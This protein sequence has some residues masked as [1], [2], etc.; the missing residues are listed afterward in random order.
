MRTLRYWEAIAEATVQAMDSDPSVF[1]LGIG[2]A[3][4]KGIFGTTL[5]ARK[6]FPARVIETP[7]CE[8][9]LTGIALG[10]ALRGLRPVLVHARCDFLVLSLNQLMNHAA[11]WE[12][13]CGRQAPV[14]VRAIVGRGW[15]QGPQHS[16]SLQAMLAHVPGLNVAMPATPYD[17]KG[18]LLAALAA[19]GPTVVLEHRALYEHSAHVPEEH[20]TL[21]TGRARL[22]WDGGDVT[23]VAASAAV[24]DAV[25]ASTILDGEGILAEVIDLRWIRPMDAGGILTSVQKTGRLVVVDTG[26]PAFGVGAE[27]L[28]LVAEAGVPLKAPPRR[29]GQREDAAPVSVPLERAH[30]GSA[31]EIVAVAKLVM[32]RLDAPLALVGA[33]GLDEGFRGP[34]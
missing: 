6:R 30:H 9:A 20:Y 26:W 2:V 22:A 12:R 29:L 21:P 15:G 7:C 4:P 34:F 19:E 11:K 25:E 33:G 5:E 16:Q 28:A 31:A 13:M 23:I 1:V 10:A 18:A 17:A 3:D 27:V 32:G 8:D 14:V 24:A